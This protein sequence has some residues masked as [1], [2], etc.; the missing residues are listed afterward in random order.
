M[1]TQCIC[2]R[3]VSKIATVRN[4]RTVAHAS[5]ID[6]NEGRQEDKMLKGTYTSRQIEM[7]RTHVG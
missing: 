5:S 1:P 7:P 3:E 6:V 2:R 4:I